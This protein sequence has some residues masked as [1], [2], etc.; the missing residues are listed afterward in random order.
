[1]RGVREGGMASFL[2]LALLCLFHASCPVDGL[3]CYCD[4]C[5]ETNYTCETDGY[6]FASTSLENGDITYARRCVSRHLP[7]SQPEPL[8]FCMTSESRNTSF[9][10][11]CCKEDFCNRDLKP[12]LHPRNKEVS[13]SGDDATWVTWKMALTIALPICAICVIVMVI[14]HIHMTKRRPARHF[15]DDSLEAPDRPILG[16]VTI[17]DML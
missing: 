1:M 17:R 4:I 7:P 10:I 8:I 11:Q 9:V 16:G 15:P 13:S 6:C 3:K 14:Y 12:P 5:L 2:A